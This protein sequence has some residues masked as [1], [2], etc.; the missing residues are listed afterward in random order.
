[1]TY[2][3][4]ARDHTGVGLPLPRASTVM[5]TDD[6]KGVTVRSQPLI[7]PV[8]VPENRTLTVGCHVT[9]KTRPAHRNRQRG[10]SSA[11]ARIKILETEAETDRDRE[12]EQ[13]R[14]RERDTDTDTERQR[15]RE[16]GEPS[17]MIC[18]S[19]NCKITPQKFFATHHL[20]RAAPC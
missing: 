2:D 19:V 18:A 14:D 4:T 17:T 15:D 10:L 8:E 7:N 6:V 9:D 3:N 13:Q 1:M 16:K 5:R 12:K 11:I 20:S